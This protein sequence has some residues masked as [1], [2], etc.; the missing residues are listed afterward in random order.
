M[1]IRSRVGFIM[2]V[3][4]LIIFPCIAAENASDIFARSSQDNEI[5]P[6]AI[7][8]TVGQ[9]A[10]AFGLVGPGAEYIDVTLALRESGTNLRLANV[11]SIIEITNLSSG[12]VFKT[13]KYVDQ[14]GSIS[15][16]LG[17][18]D[19]D[20]VIKID[21]LNTSGS[22][23]YFEKE[24]SV[25]NKTVE[26]IY[27]L[28]VG[29][30]RGRVLQ[31]NILVPGAKMFLECSGFY[32][33]VKIAHT[34]E[35]GS[36]S[37]SYLPTGVCTIHASNA[38]MVGSQTV[39]IR[40]G[41]IADADVLLESPLSSSKKLFLFIIL[42]I[43]VLVLFVYV[44]AVFFFKKRKAKGTGQAE[45]KGSGQELKPG[46]ERKAAD[47]VSVFNNRLSDI[48]QTLG[49]KEKQ[50]ID[51]L[52]KNDELG[53]AKIIY[54]LGIPKT[55]LVRILQKLETKNIIAVERFGKAKKIRLTAW[56]LEKE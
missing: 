5:S 56:I 33:E 48:Y 14:S 24:F 40:K 21:L 19:Y 54:S 20:I 30:L 42:G 9:K 18:G 11:H 55:S 35:F 25:R 31:D 15:I 8:A 26:T 4:F 43:A 7:P 27:L 2:G 3:F 10:G 45:Q 36:F 38:N 49:G 39:N 50:I 44:L 17:K 41:E 6:P 37:A 23:Y 12:E 53:Q 28:P 29:S 1:A 22:D 32:G 13:L 51:S 47:G 52:F 46:Q 16:S 34:D